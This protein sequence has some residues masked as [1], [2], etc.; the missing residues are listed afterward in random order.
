MK[1]QKIINIKRIAT[2]LYIWMT[3]SQSL[4]NTSQEQPGIS[5]R[6]KCFRTSDSFILFNIL[7]TFSVTGKCFST[8]FFELCS[9]GKH[10]HWQF[11]VKP[12][13]LSLGTTLPL[14]PSR[15]FQASFYIDS[16]VSFFSFQFFFPQT[17]N[18]SYHLCYLIYLHC[19]TCLF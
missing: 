17:S 14:T 5:K 2:P 4:F 11:W 7:I 13:P 12:L 15:N 18:L 19:L 16:H 8:I 3:T 6:V 1:N 9:L 10:Q